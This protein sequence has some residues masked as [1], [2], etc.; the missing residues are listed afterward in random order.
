[1]LGFGDGRPAQ[2]QMPAE[3]GAGFT[4]RVVRPGVGGSHPS[5]F[6]AAELLSL[7]TTPASL[8]KRE[9]ELVREE[10]LSGLIQQPGPGL[11]LGCPRSEVGGGGGVGGKVVKCAEEVST[12]DISQKGEKRC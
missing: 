10:M 3:V 7:V 6:R 8:Y 1:M 5:V 12:L 2:S 4:W 11:R 9:S